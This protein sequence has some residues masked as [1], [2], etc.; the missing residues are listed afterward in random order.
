MTYDYKIFYSLAKQVNDLF[1][2]KFF[3]RVGLMIKLIR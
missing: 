2:K 1:K 3:S